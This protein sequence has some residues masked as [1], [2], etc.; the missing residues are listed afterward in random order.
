MKGEYLLIIGVLI[1]VVLGFAAGF[2]MSSNQP[3]I[4][5]VQAQPPQ[6]PQA[7]SPQTNQPQSPGIN[8]SLIDS[9]VEYINR[10]LL[11]P[12]VTAKLVNVSIYSESLYK[13]SL[14]FEMEGQVVGESDVY[15]TKDGRTLVLKSVD[16]G[17]VEVQ[18]TEVSEDDD[19][20]IGGENAEVTLI[21]FSDFAC[22][23]CAK[24]ET[25]ILPKILEKYGDKVKFVYRDFPLPFHG[26]KSILAAKAANCAGDQGKYWDMHNILF[27][28]QTEWV[29]LD[30]ISVKQRFYAYAEELSLDMNDFKACI[31]SEKYDEEIKKDYFDGEKAGVTGTPT[32]FINGIKIVGAKPIETFY[33]IIDGELK[34]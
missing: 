32:V 25:E 30:D 15:L 14:Q 28:R 16:I 34:S 5:E 27:E 7:V 24:F 22:P 26:N 29:K 3:Q 2:F 1:G 13:L 23:Y 21:A 20:Y 18:R 6:T 9:S 10:Y 8:Q 17:G 33:E 12:G 4:C 11:Q 19:P 31:E